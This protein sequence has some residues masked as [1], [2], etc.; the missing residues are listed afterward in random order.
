MLCPEERIDGTLIEPW[1]SS[2][3]VRTETLTRPARPGHLMEDMERALIEIGTRVEG[4][5]TLPEDSP[6]R[7][8]A[9]IITPFG[10]SYENFEETGIT[11]FRYGHH[12]DGG[13]ISIHADY[14][15]DPDYEA[16]M[17]KAYGRERMQ[18]ILS[19]NTH[20]TLYYP[21]LTIK[22]AA[23]GWAVPPT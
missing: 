10:A 23:P 9:E 2:V 18:E 12:Y 14:T 17:L 6:R 15:L 3:D 4:I 20:N 5:E 1:L 11:G 8:E 7:D 13:K 22:S 21:S 19:F 16:A